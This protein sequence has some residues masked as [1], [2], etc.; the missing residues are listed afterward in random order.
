M[1]RSGRSGLASAACSGTAVDAVKQSTLLCFGWATPVKAYRCAMLSAFLET[2]L[3]HALDLFKGSN[4][5]LALA[6]LHSG[7]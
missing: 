4:S 3:L 5:L 6:Q 7:C 1:V 2:L